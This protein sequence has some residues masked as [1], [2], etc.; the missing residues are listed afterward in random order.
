M[1]RTIAVVVLA[2]A[3]ALVI[4]VGCGSASRDRAALPSV[5]GAADPGRAGSL[6]AAD[7]LSNTTIG[8]PKGTTLAFRFRAGWTGPVRGVRFHVILNP[9]G[10]HGYSGG[11]GGRMRVA[12]MRDSGTPGHRPRGR[13]LGTAVFAPS[14]DDLWP[15]VRFGNRPHVR[16]G[17][18]YHVV[19]TNPSADPRRD[20]VSVNALRSRGHRSPAPPTPDGLGVLL[21]ETRDGGATT[22]RWTSRAIESGD[23]YAPI[24]D[25]A[26]RRPRDHVG[27][28]YME[29]WVTAPRPIG[30]SARVRQ[31]L[32]TSAGRTSEITGAW[33]R[34][35][36]ARR[37]PAPLDV[38]LEAADG[39]PLAAASARGSRLSTASPEWVHVRFAHPVAVPGGTALALTASASRGGSYDTFPV[40]K[41][42][43]FGFSPRTVLATGYAQFT[44]GRG[45][46]GWT[47]WGQ[48]DRRD[49]DLQFALDVRRAGGSGP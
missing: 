19:F 26:G 37:A 44:N 42:T 49:G 22:V 41:G 38:R 8:G 20:Y 13:A 21:G 11:S 33:L 35:R 7:T 47:Q 16:A 2:G 6:V 4:A 27:M 43:E 9:T 29:A 25:V 3:V 28:G 46:T 40:R 15:F 36:R 32:R 14:R 5:S 31:L 45:W 10:R 17:R 18:L 34:V 39:T 23:R 30:G 12:L 1:R 48:R 24:V